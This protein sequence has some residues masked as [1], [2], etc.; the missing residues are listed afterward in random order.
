M[1]E[2]NYE[3]RQIPLELQEQAESRNSL[4]GLVVCAFY[5]YSGRYPEIEERERIMQKLMVSSAVK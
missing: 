5:V 1:T 3:P 4:V 2:G